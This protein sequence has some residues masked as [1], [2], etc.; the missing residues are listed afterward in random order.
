MRRGLWFVVGAGAG[1]YAMIRG[2]R[3]AE[4]FTAEGLHDRWNA[5]SLGARMLRDEV[6][7]GKADAES[8]LRERFALAEAEAFDDTPQ[9]SAPTNDR[10]LEEG[11]Q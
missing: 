2:R 11:P 7:T 6:A 9:L 3:A 5:L 1:V 4:A 8:R 10:Y